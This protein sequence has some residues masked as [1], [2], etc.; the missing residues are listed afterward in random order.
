MSDGTT[1]HASPPRNGEGDRPAQ[2]GGGGVFATTRQTIQLARRERRSGNPPEVM[3]W[4]ALRLRPGGYRF[5]RQH[6]IGAYSLD[7][8][9][10]S[11]RLAIEIDGEAHDRGN[12][13]ARDAQRDVKLES[14]GFQTLRIPAREVFRSVDDVVTAIVTACAARAPL[15]RPADGPPPHSGEVKK[16]SR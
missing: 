10:L 11:A 5:R 4:R 16:A 1:P 7:F 12:R 6:P 13:P 9:C 14:L 3:L 15:H 8:A 2:P